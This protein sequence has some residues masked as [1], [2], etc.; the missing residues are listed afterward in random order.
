MLAAKDAAGTLL[1]EAEVFALCL[2]QLGDAA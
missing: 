2:L 1:A